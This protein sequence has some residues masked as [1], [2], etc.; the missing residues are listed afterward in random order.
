M[1]SDLGPEAAR[2]LGFDRVMGYETRSI[3]TVPIVPDGD[4]VRGVLQ[5]VNATD[6]SGAAVAFDARRIALA[7]AVADLMAALPPDR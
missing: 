6:E 4:D 2:T 3:L 7:E 1:A 5:L